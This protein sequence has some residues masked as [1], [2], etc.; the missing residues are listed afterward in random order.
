MA[1]KRGWLYERHKQGR[2]CRT[3]GVVSVNDEQRERLIRAAVRAG[4]AYNMC[5]RCAPFDSKVAADMIVDAYRN[6][7]DMVTFHEFIVIVR[8]SLQRDADI[9]FGFKEPCCESDII[10]PEFYC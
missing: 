10:P 3:I 4:L 6:V 7:G 8:N 2:S 9:F 5:A 1:R